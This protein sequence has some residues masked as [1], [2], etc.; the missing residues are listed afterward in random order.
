[1]DFKKTEAKWWL[2]SPQ[3]QQAIVN[4]NDSQM[5]IFKNY[6]FLFE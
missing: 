4:M 6:S 5:L 2:Q 3:I 1:M